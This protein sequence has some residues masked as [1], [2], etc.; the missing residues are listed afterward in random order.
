MENYF[1]A[2]ILV[3]IILA[4]WRS[5]HSNIKTLEFKYSVY[6]LRDELRL[7]GIKGEVDSESWLYNHL[8]ESFSKSIEESY[9]I[10]LFRLIILSAVYSEDEKYLEFSAKFDKALK[11]E[12]KL[13][14][15][16]KSYYSVIR[17]Y[18]REQHHISW[19]YIIKPFFAPIVGTT[20][21]VKFFNQ[22]LKTNLIFTDPTERH[23]A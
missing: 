15:L 7:L 22:W 2:S 6:K 20:T 13:N 1:G 21:L 11:E 19:T 5:F 12:P 23:L 10:T 17:K 14:T 18:I 4:V 16:Q 3:L 8:D 9:Y